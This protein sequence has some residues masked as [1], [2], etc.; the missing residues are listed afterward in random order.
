MFY[1]VENVTQKLI[2][3]WMMLIAMSTLLVLAARFRFLAKN[4]KTN[5][6]ELKQLPDLK[7]TDVQNAP[8]KPQLIL[9]TQSD[10]E[11][12]LTRIYPLLFPLLQLFNAAMAIS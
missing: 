5:T 7:F 6:T 8:L 11:V 4:A 10:V 2:T 3:A 1:I 12:H 9:L